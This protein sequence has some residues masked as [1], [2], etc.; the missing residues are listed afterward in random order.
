M[1]VVPVVE[2]TVWSEGSLAD[3]AAD[4]FAR[5]F[6]R[7]RAAVSWIG[8]T[9]TTSDDPSFVELTHTFPTP[10]PWVTPAVEWRLLAEVRWLVDWLGRVS[11]DLGLDLAVRYDNHDLGH[12]RHGVIDAA[13]TED[14][15]AVWQRDLERLERDAPR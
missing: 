8:E 4:R 13:V 6:E 1:T 2:L 12:I 7:D 10:G 3:G 11:G 9:V 14:L 5:A 15:L